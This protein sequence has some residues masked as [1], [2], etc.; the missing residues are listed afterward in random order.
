[1]DIYTLSLLFQCLV[2]TPLLG[3]CKMQVKDSYFDLL[4]L[5]TYFQKVLITKDLQGILL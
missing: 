5:Y 2:Y 3:E 1:M 4:V